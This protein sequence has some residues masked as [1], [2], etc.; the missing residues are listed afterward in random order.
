MSPTPRSNPSTEPIRVRSVPP[1]GLPTAEE[2]ADRFNNYAGGVNPL[3]YMGH[4]FAADGSYGYRPRNY[5]KRPL[6]SSRKPPLPPQPRPTTFDF[7]QDDEDALSM[8]VPESRRKAVALA[9]CE[10]HHNDDSTP[11]CTSWLSPPSS[12]SSPCVTIARSSVLNKYVFFVWR[13]VMF[14][15]SLASLIVA[16]M[17][18]FSY[19]SIFV[20]ATFLAAV[21][22]ELVLIT[23]VLVLSCQKQPE[24]REPTIVR[25]VAVFLFF[26]LIHIVANNVLFTVTWVSSC[27]R[28]PLK[29]S[30]S[31]Q[32]SLASITIPLPVLCAKRW[33]LT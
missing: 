20:F 22:K 13:I 17:Y 24:W 23:A 3:G 12:L 31:L 10:H 33:E 9:P 32:P 25:Y 4:E 18:G 14:S 29:W 5:P 8:P 6:V 30:S 21:A 26:P 28:L 1:Y 11:F 15:Y 7:G 2:Y 16:S 27:L 19:R